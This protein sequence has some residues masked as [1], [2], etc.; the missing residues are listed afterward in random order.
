MGGGRGG[1]LIHTCKPGGGGRGGLLIHTC[2]PGGGGG[3][4]GAANTHM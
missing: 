1:L 2:K 4:G 3:R